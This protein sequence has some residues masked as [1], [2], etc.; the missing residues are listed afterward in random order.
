M[1]EIT[2]REFCSEVAALGMVL[3]VVAAVDGDGKTVLE[4]NARKKRSLGQYFTERTCWLQPQIIDFIRN[5]KC[6]VAYD[7]F[8]GSGSLFPPV[9]N[10]VP[11]ITKTVGLDIDSA[12]GWMVNDSLI[13]IPSEENAIII[14][15]PPYISNYSAS[16]KRLG[17]ELKKY[18][19]MT[20]YDDVYLLALDRMLEAQRNVVAIIPETFINSPYDQKNLLFSISILEDNPFHDT[21]TPVVVACFDSKPKSF[22]KI[23]IYKGSE[24]V[25]TLQDVE[26]SRLVPDHSVALRFND[27]LGWLGVR[28]VDTTNPDD[29]LHFDFKENIDYDWEQGIKVSSRLLTLVSIEVPK[30]KRQLFIDE[31]NRLLADLRQRSHDIMLSPFKGNMKNGVRR[32]RLD[33][34]TCR[35]II[36]RAYHTIVDKNRVAKMTQ[37]CLFKEAM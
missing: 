16:R 15:N 21:D 34:Q 32:R 28:C 7:P 19:T 35:A 27:P 6:S 22:S 13:K 3:P 30:P 10:T 26:D 23:R 8:A 11:E 33:F 5:S 1:K 4:G 18:F 25:C 24:F 2:R 17:D 29:M 20:K 12:Q 36:E 14:T 37:G 31:C 9:T